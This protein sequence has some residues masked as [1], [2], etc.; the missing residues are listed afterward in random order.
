VITVKHAAGGSYPINLRNSA[1]IVL[2]DPRKALVLIRNGNQWN[3]LFGFLGSDPAPYL[4]ADLDVQAKK[5]TTTTVNGD[6]IIEPNGTGSLSPL[7]AHKA[8]GKTGTR[9]GS[10]FIRDVSATDWV[11]TAALDTE[12]SG[13]TLAIGGTNATIINIGRTGAT[14]VLYGSITEVHTTN[15]YVA[16]KLMT[17]NDGGLAATGG[18]SGFEI[19]EDGVATGYVKTTTD[20]QGW[21]FKAPGNA[22]TETIIPGAIKESSTTSARSQTIASGKSGTLPMDFS[23]SV[24]HVITVD[25][26]LLGFEK[27]TA[28]GSLIVGTSG[29][30]KVF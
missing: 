26:G 13:G 9:W 2:D 17:L 6:V 10:A 20:R 16:D 4:S 11:R 18:D 1:D 29:K 15:T 24:D 23:I 3:E 8:F 22:S 5:I 7:T 21:E 27:I 14:I 30:V 19:E 28:I 12:S 25:G